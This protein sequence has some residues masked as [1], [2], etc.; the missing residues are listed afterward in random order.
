VPVRLSSRQVEIP[1]L[2]GAEFPVVHARGLWDELSA[3]SVDAAVERQQS[4]FSWHNAHVDAGGIALGGMTLL[5]L[6]P[7]PL[8]F[9]LLSLR[10]RSEGVGDSYNPFGAATG[11]GL[12]R[13]GFGLSLLNLVVLVLLPLGGS[14]LCAWSLLQID[15]L[16]VVP[17]LCAAGSIVLG[18]LCQLALKE[19]SE[20]RDAV[21]R[22][23]SNPP[24]A[25]QTG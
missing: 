6:A 8:I 7:L 22:S 2:M 23:H 3:L 17:L 1:G 14:L 10:R 11:E 20:L 13:V 18:A 4:R 21:T 25:P 19:L 24:P 15:R 9:L 5:Q 12:P 16:P